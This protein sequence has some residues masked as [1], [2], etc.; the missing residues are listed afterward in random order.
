MQPGTVVI[1]NLQNPREK[2]IGSLQEIVSAGIFIRGLDVNSFADWL[3][4]IANP[5]TVSAICPTSIFLPMH[6]VV[7]CYADEEI[8]NIPSFSTQFSQR[9]GK[10]ISEYLG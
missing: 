3:N 9:T 4:G 2:M 6:R 1:L 5:E 7:S 10:D 8:G